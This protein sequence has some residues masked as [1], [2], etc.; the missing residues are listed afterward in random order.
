VYQWIEIVCFVSNIFQPR[1]LISQHID[2]KALTHAWTAHMW[3]LNI[4]LS[5]RKYCLFN[6]SQVDFIS[7]TIKLNVLYVGYTWANQA[8][9]YLIGMDIIF[10][11]MGFKNDSL[12]IDDIHLEGGTLLLSEWRTK[13]SSILRISLSFNEFI[14]PRNNVKIENN[15]I[16][17]KD[18]FQSYSRLYIDLSIRDLARYWVTTD[19]RQHAYLIISLIDASRCSLRSSASANFSIGSSNDISAWIADIRWDNNGELPVWPFPALYGIIRG[20]VDGMRHV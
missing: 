12:I 11:Q 13:I 15:L 1:S 10:R 16:S 14:A 20:D 7:Q 8:K 4:I 6:Q 9:K 3:K 2:D 18:I 19:G 5:Y 17:A